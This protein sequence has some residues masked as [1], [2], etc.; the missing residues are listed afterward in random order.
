M[1]RGSSAPATISLDRASVFAMPVVLPASLTQPDPESGGKIVPVVID[2]VRVRV[3][4]ET[5]GPTTGAIVVKFRPVAR[6]GQT[7]LVQLAPGE[8]HEIGL[9]PGRYEL[10]V[11]S[12]PEHAATFYRGSVLEIPAN[13]R[14]VMTL[15][16]ALQ[17]AAGD[18]GAGMAAISRDEFE[19]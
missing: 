1:A 18:R 14:G 19:R 12:G 13:T 5:T 10:L 8:P 2:G 11:R 15:K 6:R 3:I 9:K 16:L 4:A 17:M 7:V